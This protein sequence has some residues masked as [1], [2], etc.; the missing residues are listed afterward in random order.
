MSLREPASGLRRLAAR[1]FRLSEFGEKLR[2]VLP[3]LVPSDTQERK[4][5][6]KE[7]RALAT[8]VNMGSVLQKLQPD[9]ARVNRDLGLI[10][11]ALVDQIQGK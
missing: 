4:L 8:L 9:V 6:S 10:V 3:L 5:S 11:A 2:E 1:D 7:R